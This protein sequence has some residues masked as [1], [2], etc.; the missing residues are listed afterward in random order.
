MSSFDENANGEIDWFLPHEGWTQ[1]RKPNKCDQCDSNFVSASDLQRHTKQ[2]PT[3]HGYTHVKKVLQTVEEHWSLLY[4][5][6]MVQNMS[7]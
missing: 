3:K 4:L 2:S 7:K 5:P 6:C 1:L